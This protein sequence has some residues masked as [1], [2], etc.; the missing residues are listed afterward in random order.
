MILSMKIHRVTNRLRIE[1][2]LWNQA[3][4][5]SY[6]TKYLWLLVDLI[7]LSGLICLDL[8]LLEPESDLLLSI[9]NTIRTVA[10]ITT[11]VDSIIS[12]TTILAASAAQDGPPTTYLTLL[13]ISSRGLMYFISKFNGCIEQKTIADECN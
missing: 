8:T 13:I 2:M 1:A 3:F 7:M 9:L 6:V 5:M 11:N 12:G 10:Y 4:V